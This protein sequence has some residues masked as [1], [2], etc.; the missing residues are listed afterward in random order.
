MKMSDKSVF[1]TTGFLEVRRMSSV[2]LE[3]LSQSATFSK[4]LH[5]VMKEQFCSQLF[6]LPVYCII[7][8]VL[9]REVY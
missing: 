2:P 3:C 8:F 5:V 4:D 1:S 7:L 6:K 9:R